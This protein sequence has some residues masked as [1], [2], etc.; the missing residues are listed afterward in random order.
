MTNL[1]DA[2][3]RDLAADRDKA[4]QTWFE[5]PE[6]KLIISLLPPLETEMQRD[7]FHTL[8]QGA[9]RVGHESGPI[10]DRR[11]DP[12]RHDESYAARGMLTDIVR[13]M[14]YQMSEAPE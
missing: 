8:L 5:R 1:L 13:A 10:F 6:T 4:F 3:L 9:F 14:E 2:K 11:C 12:G 7:C